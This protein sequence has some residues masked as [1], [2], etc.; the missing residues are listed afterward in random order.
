[1]I[2]NLFDWA[3]DV[4]AGSAHLMPHRGQFIVDVVAIESN[5][6]HQPSKPGDELVVVLNG[7]LTLTDDSDRKEQIIRAGEMVL[8]PAGWAGLYRVQAENGVF[9]ESTTRCVAAYAR[10]EIRT[11]RQYLLRCVFRLLLAQRSRCQQGL[12]WQVKPYKI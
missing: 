1:M 5:A 8:I 10:S 9:R 4:T 7:I 11:N 6:V 12:D 2:R 3:E